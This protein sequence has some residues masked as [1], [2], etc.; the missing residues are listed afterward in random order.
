MKIVWS[1]KYL[2]SKIFS[3]RIELS[4]LVNRSSDHFETNH[5]SVTIIIPTRDRADLLEA[6]LESI[7]KVTKYENFEILLVDNDSREIKTSRL[8]EKCLREGHKILRYPGEFNFSKIINFA[9]LDSRSEFICVLNNDITV[10]SPNWLA[11]LIDHASSPGVGVAGSFLTFPSGSIQHA[12]IALGFSGVATH[13]WRGLKPSEVHIATTRTC[14]E[15]SAVTF[16]AAVARRDL[17]LELQGLDESLKVGLNDV[18]FCV[19]A[20]NAGYKTILCQHSQLIHLESQSRPSMFSIRG[21]SQATS[22][23]WRFMR[24]HGGLIKDP[25]FSRKISR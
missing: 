12:G 7:T 22:E 15:V 11:A 3:R 25:Y 1:A 23:V 18:D 4:H 19:R 24:V 5:P 20:M 16:A 10:V 8:F 14:F 13:V 2:W 9:I 17:F 21:F 6:C